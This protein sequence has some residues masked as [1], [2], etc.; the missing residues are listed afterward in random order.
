MQAVKSKPDCVISIDTLRLVAMQLMNVA[1]PTL[2]I[3]PL[4][5]KNI[6]MDYL[7]FQCVTR[8]EILYNR[9]NAFSRS[10]IGTGDAIMS[11]IFEG[12][13]AEFELRKQMD[14]EFLKY[15]QRNADAINMT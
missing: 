9:D 10:F 8:I 12:E 4:D 1:H 15:K 7:C 6:M 2:I 5:V 11:L 13:N 3:C 14:L